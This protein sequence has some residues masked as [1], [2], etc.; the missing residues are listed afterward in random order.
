MDADI[1]GSDGRWARRSG[2]S[3]Q[4]IYVA[5]SETTLAAAEEF[6]F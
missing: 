3:Q 2:A 1:Y 5:G 4:W 6:V